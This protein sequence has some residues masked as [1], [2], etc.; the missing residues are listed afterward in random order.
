[1]G[2]LRGKVWTFGDNINSESILASGME[3]QMDLAL[4]HVLEFYDPE[5]PKLAKPGDFIVGG[6][7]FGASSG[8]PAGEVIREKGI[9][10]IIC[11]SAGRVF[12]RNTWNMA[13]PVL[14]CPGVRSKFE[15][16]DEIE[17][18]IDAGLVRVVKTGEVLKCEEIP[19]I[20]KDIYKAGGMVGWIRSRRKEYKTLDQS[21][22]PTKVLKDG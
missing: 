12:F 5:F 8:R 2:Y 20:L 1:M 13:L 9:K 17:V 10:A 19:W 4:A 15:K 11:E 3:G 7:N 6:R 22:P 16:G 14:V 21:E 18:D